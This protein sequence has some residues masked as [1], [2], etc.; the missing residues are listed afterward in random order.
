MKKT[1]SGLVVPNHTPTIEPRIKDHNDSSSIKA[2]MSGMQ[3]LEKNFPGLLKIC[4]AIAMRL[5][6]FMNTNRI[7]ATDV[8]FDTPK[9]RN[10]GYIV[11][12]VYHKGKPLKPHDVHFD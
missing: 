4:Y 3:K 10:D 2:Q 8:A 5:T 9:W 1:T 6:N 12:R 7:R 11:F